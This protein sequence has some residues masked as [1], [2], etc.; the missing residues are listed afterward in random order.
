MQSQTSIHERA[1]AERFGQADCRKSTASL[2]T[3]REPALAA[4]ESDILM[5]QLVINAD[6][7]GFDTDTLSATTRLMEQGRITSATI[8]T[9]F[10]ASEAAMRFARDHAKDFSFGLHF[11]I[12]EGRP[13]GAEPVPSLVGK[14]GEF[15]APISQRLRALTGAL[16]RKDLVNELTAQLSI[17]ADHG[18]TP[19]HLDSHGHLH[20]F[21]PVLKA[22]LPVMQRFGIRR[23]R[24][25][26]TSYDNQRAHNRLIDGHCNRA[27]TASGC[28]MTD[29][30]FNTRTQDKSWFDQFVAALP[31]GKAE[32]GV[33]PG[34]AEDW[35]RA[36]MQ[37]LDDPE[38]FTK[39]SSHQIGLISYHDI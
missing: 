27:F 1:A 12:A 2:R 36:E 10:P 17:L 22:M 5:R 4:I 7:L 33:H 6:D 30:F 35:R 11:N 20:K 26:Q 25:A 9:G 28:D 24:R 16:R 21:P 39:L 18:V 13:A 23:I 19:T 32:L 29:H 37:A 8:L 31:T 34:Q 38:F 15:H 3:K 14:G